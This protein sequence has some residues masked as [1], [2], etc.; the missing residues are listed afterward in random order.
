[1]ID[2][3]DNP[4][5]VHTGAGGRGAFYARAAAVVVALDRGSL[6][7]GV[8]REGRERVWVRQHIQARDK[9]LL[10]ANLDSIPGG[11]ARARA[12]VLLAEVLYERL[13]D[14]RQHLER[15]RV[16]AQGDPA[17][18]A[19]IV[20][21]MSSAAISVER[22]ADAEAR[23]LAVLPAAEQADP[24]VERA[25][26]FALAWARA[27]S[28][29][30][31]DDVCDRWNA[32]SAIPGHLAG[33][34]ERVAGQ[35]YVWRGEITKA[36]PVFERLLTLSDE[37]GEVGSYAWAHLHLCELALRTG[38]WSTAGLLLDEWAETAEPE[39]FV[40]PYQLRCR[41]LLAAGRGLA[42]EAMTL[43]TE[44]IDRAQEIGFQWD[45]LEGLRARGTAALLT[46]E[47]ARAAESL[48]AVWEHTTREGVDEPGVFPVAPDLVEALVELGEFG[49]A[50]AVTSRLRT[51]AGRQQ[52]PWGLVTAGRCGALI[53]LAAPPC[54]DEAAAELGEAA[55]SY[56][57][58]GLRFDRA[59]V[60]LT[61]GRAER[62]LK[63]WAAARRSLE[64][65]AAAFDEIGSTGWSARARAEIG[66]IGARRPGRAGELTPTERRV[67]ELAAM[68]RSNKEIAQCLFV[69]INT[70]EGHLSRAYA[71]LGVRSRAQLAHRLGG[72][73]ASG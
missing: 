54:D 1:V 24:E 36:K 5:V 55:D 25:V 48:A 3:A 27:L 32:A 9:E 58:L 35:R 12:S 16:E 57:E 44:T 2:F 67:A 6:S 20:A 31:L 7:T 45:W 72:Q 60:P 49:Q 15:A 10:T 66:R 53:R 47:P 26:L 69:T 59:R 61:L 18:H 19:L 22:I 73:G 14:Y 17:L 40:E 34:P 23:A 4:G 29:R 8:D 41:A 30:A 46:G 70:V 63:R 68:G 56:A 28:G 39:I 42:D 71:K 33:S 51:L 50:R 52:H 38:D 43:S 13:D 21:K 11:S 64:L 37:R 62:R 65:A